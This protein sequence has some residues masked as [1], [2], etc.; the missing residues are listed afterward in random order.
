MMVWA[1]LEP[2]R[3]TLVAA[4]FSIRMKCAAH[5][6]KAADAFKTMPA[7]KCNFYDI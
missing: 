1:G 2:M 5:S 3:I 7:L 6:V 4:L